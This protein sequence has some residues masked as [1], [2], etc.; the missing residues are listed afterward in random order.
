MLLRDKLK[1]ATRHAHETLEARVILTNSELSFDSYIWYLQCLLPFYRSLSH[2]FAAAAPRDQLRTDCGSRIT[3]LE[4]DLTYLGHRHQCDD[5]PKDFLPCVT[6]VPELLGVSYV[7]EG[8]ALGGRALYAQLHARWG[9]EP[10]TGAS[11]LFGYGPDTGQRWQAFVAA[12]NRVLLDEQDERR[13]I[14]AA[15][16][17]FA[18]LTAWFTCNQWRP[19][20][21]RPK[22][23]SRC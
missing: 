18:G 16:Q 20:L 14:T 2:H 11:F 1:A 7:I 22:K 8:A 19:S 21:N 12:L 17:T 9:I 3:W 15:C 6:V 13:C 10:D 5:A 23:G 4:Q